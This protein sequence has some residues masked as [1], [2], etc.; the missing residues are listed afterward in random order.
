M[1]P[2]GALNQRAHSRAM[3]LGSVLQVDAKAP[4]IPLFAKTSGDVILVTA[5]IKNMIMQS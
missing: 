3:V 4:H 1:K 5:A 2:R